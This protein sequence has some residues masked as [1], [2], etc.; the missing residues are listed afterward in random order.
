M[1]H[2]A[3]KSGRPPTEMTVRSIVCSFVCLH[4]S[5]VA[6]AALGRTPVVGLQSLGFALPIRCLFVC[7]FVCLFGLCVVQ[8]C[9]A[10]LARVSRPV[11]VGA[12]SSLRQ[13]LSALRCNDRTPSTPLR[14]NRSFY[15]VRRVQHAALQQCCSPHSV[16]HTPHTPVA[17]AREYPTVRTREHR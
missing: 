14:C 7:L 5:F 15:S 9:V 17:A 12:A 8:R 11:S 13:T 10:I 2:A 3:G 4:C 6:F 1:Q 16:Q